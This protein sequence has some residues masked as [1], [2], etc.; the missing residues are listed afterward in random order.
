[1][2]QSTR[3]NVALPALFL[4][5]TLAGCAGFGSKPT[6]IGGFGGTVDTSNIGLALRAQQALTAG[7]IAGGVGLAERAVSNRPE[8]AG[9]RTLLGNAYLQGGRFASAEAAY[10][11][12]LSLVSSQAGVPLKLVLSVVAQGKNEAALQLIEEYRGAIDPAD[13]G[14]AMALAGQPG[15]A[16]AMLDEA[17]RSPA[18]D[19]RVR[20][21]L[22]LAHA[23]AGD[24]AQ[25]RAVAAQDLPSDQVDARVTQWMSFAKP[26]SSNQQ[27][28]AL[29]GVSPAVSDPGQP[30]R[31]ALR[32]TAT[33][34]AQ[35]D[36]PTTQ[37]AEEVAVY[38]APA[39]PTSSVEAAVQAAPTEVEPA[40]A[41]APQA[42]VDPMPVLAAVEP[43]PILPAVTLDA[44]RRE[45]VR[46][47]GAL[48]QASELRRAAAARFSVGG[49]SVVQLGAYGSLQGVQAAWAKAVRRHPELDRYAP[50]TAPFASAR[51]TVYRLSVKGFGS[52]RQARL[53]CQSLQKSGGT[54]FVR[55]VAGDQSVRFAQR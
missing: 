48:P 25:A 5:L 36:V 24:W 16:V 26:G 37:P 1:M 43:Q 50:A 27:V 10:R 32:S 52:D 22:A 29:I 53:L 2:R 55:S 44:I 46:A 3:C 35:A 15:N 18:A 31:L 14:L 19:S 38:S 9:F 40:M 45:P 49:N 4:S 21:N 30:I 41:E 51:G 7:D 11:D 28:A 54:C 39:L 12:A 8:D 6:E 20:Q 34:M 17:A 13:A 33:R 47:S 23:L 42:V